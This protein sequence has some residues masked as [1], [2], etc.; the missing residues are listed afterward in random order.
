MQPIHIPDHAVTYTHSNTLLLRGLAG[1]EESELRALFS[2][3]GALKLLRV[4]ARC[5]VA[6][7][8]YA[9]E[10]CAARAREEL[11]DECVVYT[12]VRHVLL[13]MHCTDAVYICDAA[14]R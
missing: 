11:R 12:K 9:H 13:S 5:D 8:V 4:I 10:E 6:L 7:V 3:Y 14:S 1:R 2:R